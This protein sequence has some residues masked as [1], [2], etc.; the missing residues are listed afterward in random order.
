MTWSHWEIS[1][2]ITSV[3]FILGVLTLFWVSQNWLITFLNTH[4]QRV[5]ESI[6]NDWYGLVYMLVFVFVFGM[7]ALIVGQPDAWIFMNFQLIALTFCGYFLNIRIANYYLYP[8]VLVFMI[9][10]RSLGYWQSWGHALALLLFFTT[11]RTLRKRVPLQ[12]K[13]GQ[14]TL[15]FL[16]CAGFGLVLWWFMWLKFNLSWGT[17]WQEWGYLMIFEVLLYIYA[18][19][20]SAN[21]QLKQNLVSFANHDAL[22]KTENFAAYTTAINYHLT[23]SRQNGVPL[24]MMMFDIDHFKRVNDTYGHLAGDQ[25]LQHVTQVAE[26]V[27]EANNPNIALYRTGGEEFNVLFPSYDLT[28]ARLVAEQLFAAVNHLVVPFNGHQIQLS[29]SVG[30]AQLQPED[31]TPTEFYRSVDDNLYAAKKHGRMQIVAK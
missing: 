10:N 6:I 17:Y 21:A 1:P 5:N 12:T 20:L 23:A 13:V 25:I 31:T 19:M 15:Y 22:T 24:T 4:Y 2:F 29:I 27:F 14:V 30:I 11:L 18:S 26:T 28:E 16:T 9:F 8:L 3:F 7:Q